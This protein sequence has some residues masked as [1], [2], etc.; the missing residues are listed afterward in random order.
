M[1]TVIG[2]LFGSAIIKGIYGGITHTHMVWVFIFGPVFAVVF[3]ALIVL[4]VFIVNSVWNGLVV[5][6]KLFKRDKGLDSEV[7]ET[8]DAFMT[9]IKVAVKSFKEKHCPI[10]NWVEKGEEK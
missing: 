5:V 4:V 1:G 3:I 9:M 10:I 6:F 8:Q 7:V 2:G